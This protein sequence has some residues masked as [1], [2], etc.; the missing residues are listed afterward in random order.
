MKQGKDGTIMMNRKN[1]FR[2]FTIYQ[3]EEEQEY[4]RRRHQEGWKFTGVTFPGIY[5]FAQCEPE[6]VVYQLDYNQRRIEN[7][8][9]YIK[10]YSD[11]G[12]E[13]ICDMMGYSYFRKPALEMC[14]Q[15]E[16][17]N[18]D[19][20]KR[21]M[22]DRVFKGRMIPLI[23][24]FFLIIIPQMLMWT[25]MPIAEAIG[26]KILYTVIFVLYVTIFVKYVMMYRRYT[27]R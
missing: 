22:L 2:F 1:E 12:W 19:D 14:G 9:E 4:L 23:V 10:M 25:A 16:I 15:E 6:D 18:D 27:R 21:D 13:Y 24:I 5:H 17:F 8:S 3:Y 26:L 7:M 20:S 11:C